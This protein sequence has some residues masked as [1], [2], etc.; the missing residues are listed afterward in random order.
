V[1]NLYAANDNLISNIGKNIYAH[2]YIS[3]MST[4]APMPEIPPVPA[5]TVVTA[6]VTLPPDSTAASYID[7][8]KDTP[9]RLGMFHMILMI[10][11]VVLAG[12]Y[13]KEH[14]YDKKSPGA[15]G[16]LRT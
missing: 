6:P 2:Q 8:M 3:K 16:F 13:L 9:N 5:S 12:L 10:I 15:E 11:L 14:F 7:Y 4:P 1:D